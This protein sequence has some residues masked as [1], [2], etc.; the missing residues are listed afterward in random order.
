MIK[1]L[2]SQIGVYTTDETI[3]ISHRDRTATEY[4][5]KP[6]T[7][8]DKTFGDIKGGPFTS[9]PLLPTI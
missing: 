2:G 3:P 1:K 4:G 8:V 6:V 5:R 7:A 9:P